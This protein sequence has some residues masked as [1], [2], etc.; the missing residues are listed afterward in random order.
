M[1]IPDP[2]NQLSAEH[3]MTSNTSSSDML[4][5]QAS[6]TADFAFERHLGSSVSQALV[7]EANGGW[8]AESS[9][10]PSINDKWLYELSSLDSSLLAFVS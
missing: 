5:F 3:T 8:N 1:S 6:M 9:I 10:Q 4:D 7:S 2:A